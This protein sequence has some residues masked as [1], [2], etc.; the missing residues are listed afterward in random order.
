MNG[1]DG[2]VKGRAEVL[3]SFEDQSAGTVGAS[4]RVV[5]NSSTGSEGGITGLFRCRVQTEGGCTFQVRSAAD[6]SIGIEDRQLV[7]GS[8]ERAAAERDSRV[9]E[10]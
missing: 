5:G 2:R 4:I 6:R 7:E 3:A 9:D 1:R 8:L 10:N